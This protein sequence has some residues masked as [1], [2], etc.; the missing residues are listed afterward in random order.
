[1]TKGPH[2]SELT[3]RGKIKGG[4][5]MMIDVYSHIVTRKY[6]DALDKMLPSNVYARRPHRARLW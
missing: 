2:L 4:G 3:K 5:E 6:K 1:M